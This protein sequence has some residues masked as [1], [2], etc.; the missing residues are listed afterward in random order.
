M[1]ESCF[2][3]FDGKELKYLNWMVDKPIGTVIIF[4][5]M[6]EHSAR[7]ERFASFLNDNDYDVYAMDFR[8][9][10]MNIEGQ[11]KGFFSDKEGWHTVIDDMKY[12]IDHV[13]EKSLVKNL[14]LLGHSM[15][16]LLLRSYLIKYYDI[17]VKKFILV[18]TPA[19]PSPAILN[20]ASLL[21]KIIKARGGR[22]P[23]A[24]MDKLVF[25]S[26]AKSMSS[27]ETSFDWLSRDKEVVQKYIDDPFCGFV[28]TA[29]FY[30]DLFYG[31][32]YVN[33]TSNIA[34]M[35]SSKSALIISG[36]DDPA[37]DFGNGPKAIYHQFVKRLKEENVK[38]IIYPG[39]RHELLN[40]VD[41]MVVYKD[42]LQFIR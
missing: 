21:S 31:L 5:G 16:S 2:R 8:G 32:R 40:E 42:I 28:C 4:H 25:G 10:R 14:T 37:G 30:H 15:G 33:S 20:L 6:A 23:S 13:Y 29:S 24:L 11:N 3:S 1:E 22:K 41:Y 9:H 35:D 38:L 18:G 27:P 36:S 39:Y 34:K 7:Y 12:F 19:A 17:R 26:Y